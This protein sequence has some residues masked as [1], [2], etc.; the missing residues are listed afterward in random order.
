MK[1][2]IKNTA[3]LSL[4]LTYTISAMEDPSPSN[5]NTAV[6]GGRNDMAKALYGKEKGEHG[7]FMIDYDEKAQA[8]LT[9]DINQKLN[10]ESIDGIAATFDRVIF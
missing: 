3:L 2:I 10:E 1:K 7:F 9:H 6:I 8:N 5:Y 4:V